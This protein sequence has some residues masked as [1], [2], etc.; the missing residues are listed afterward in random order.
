[1][2]TSVYPASTWITTSNPTGPYISPGAASAGLVRYHNN[3]T[4]VYDGN[5]WLTLGGGSSVGL[6]SAAEQAISWVLKKMDQEKAAQDLA[7]K[8]P[9]VADALDAVRLAE[10]Q[11]Q[12]VVVLCTI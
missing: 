6:T 12:T 10:Q 7:Q 8:H 2:I 11:L 4:Q 3:Q 1:M 5:A 9:A